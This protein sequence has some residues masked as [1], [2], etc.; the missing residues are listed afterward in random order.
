MNTV[1]KIKMRIT[2]I[3]CPSCESIQ[4]LSVSEIGKDE[5]GEFVGMDFLCSACRLIVATIYERPRYDP[6]T[7]PECKPQKTMVQ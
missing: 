4:R 1:K 2:H 5:T 3:W 6:R 7:D